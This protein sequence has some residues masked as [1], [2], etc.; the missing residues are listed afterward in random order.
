MLDRTI[1]RHVE[2]PPQAQ[3]LAK[4]RS[5]MFKEEHAWTN[6]PTEVQAR[7]LTEAH[8]WMIKEI[9]KWTFLLI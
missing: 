6:R 8:I 5:W 7:M 1:D 3:M 4:A 9:I 2:H